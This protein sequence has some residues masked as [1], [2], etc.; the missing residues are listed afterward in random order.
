MAKHKKRKKLSY[1]QA[2]KACGKK[3]GTVI[4]AAYR[5]CVKTKHPTKKRK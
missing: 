5:K 2:Q 3:F 1:R 4:S